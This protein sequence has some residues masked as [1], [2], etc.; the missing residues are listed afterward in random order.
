MPNTQE[1]LY[2]IRGDVRDPSGQSDL[3]G[4]ETGIDFTKNAIA[5]P[6]FRW[7]DRISVTDVYANGGTL[8]I[9]IYCPQCSGSLMI[10]SEKKEVRF[11]NGG[12]HGG[13]LS[14]SEFRCVYQGCGLHIRIED[15]VAKELS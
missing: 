12:E 7:R 14:V 3:R 15:N 11:E 4:V 8:M 5:H 10:R 6:E 1:E 13:R 2:E 9:H